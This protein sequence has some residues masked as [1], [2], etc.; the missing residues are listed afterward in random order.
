MGELQKGDTIYDDNGQPCRV[1][2]A[3]PVQ[4]GRPCYEV[5][6]SDGSTIVA[7]AD[8]LWQVE[9][10]TSRKHGL[11]HKVL[12]TAEMAPSVR[13]GSDKRLNYSVSVAGP[14]WALDAELP[15][16]PYILGCWLGD[17]ANRSGHICKTPD[18]FE[19]IAADGHELGIEQ[20]RPTN[21]AVTRRIVGLTALLRANKLLHNKH[22]PAPYFRASETQ[23]RALLAGLLDTDGYI[24]TDGHVIFAVTNE[25]LAKDT[26]SL[27]ATLGYKSAFRSR[28][29]ILNGKDCGTAWQVFFVPREQ[30]FRLP[31]KAARHMTFARADC[32]RRF[33]AS[34]QPVASRPVR[35]ITVDSPNSLFLVGD[36]CIPTHNSGELGNRILGPGPVLVTSTG[37]DLIRNTAAIRAKVGPVYVFNP[38]A[39]GGIRSTIQFGVL[40]GCEAPAVATARAADL[41]AGTPMAQ[42]Q[43]N[44]EWVERANSALASLMHAAALGGKTMHHVQRWVADPD[45]AGGEVLRHLKASPEPAMCWEALQFFNAGKPQ[46]SIC[47]TIMPALRWLADP[48]ATQCAAGGS[49]DV[50]RFLAEQGTIY[51]LAEKDGLVAPLVTVFAGH[52]LRTAR[53]IAD[54]R[55]HERLTPGF[56]VVLDEA[57]SI[58]PLPL[59]SWTSDMGKRNIS[60][61]IGA[62]SLSQLK[63]RWGENGAGA[64]LTNCGT[65]MVFGG[66]KDTAGLNTFSALAGERHEEGRRAPLLTPAQFQQLLPLHAVLFTNGI[67]P[68]VGKPAMVWDRRD[69]KMARLAM[70]WGPRWAAV[71]AL[72]KSWRR[73]PVPEPHRPIAALTAGPT[74]RAEW[75]P[76]V[77][78]GGDHHN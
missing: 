30:V 54:R 77:T 69:F 3:W 66:T 62:Q 41:L 28:P 39:I 73:K 29:A 52:I 44:E 58:C 55:P 36:Q 47:M 10:R 48:V 6:F 4:H 27:L 50:E 49:F 74:V 7:D 26:R 75:K 64:I 15:I 2:T 32:T 71:S 56:R 31:R 61:H 18:L 65:V 76:G 53:W 17:G 24:N 22:I 16:D 23:R 70:V 60:M 1:V 33:I 67:L 43:R 42:A 68:V 21:K 14:M 46:A 19:I 8:H 40:A 45:A 63:A 34:I 20:T 25:R 38:C 9:T 51:L 37:G 35:C 57:P 59:P 72:T 12:T 78:V 13:V 11:A 5:A